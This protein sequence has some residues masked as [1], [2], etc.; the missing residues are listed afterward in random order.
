M[1]AKNN[2]QTFL[3]N[4]IAP[5]SDPKIFKLS[6]QLHDVGV[7]SE[8]TGACVTGTCMTGA[9]VTGACVTGTCVTGAG[10]TG[11]CVTG[12]EVVGS[13]LEFT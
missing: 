9:C 3:K 2:I 11:A 5:F 6:K 10:V 4:V 12:A 13:A 8:V 1:V 7:G